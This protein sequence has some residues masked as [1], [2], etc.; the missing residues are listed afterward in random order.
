M[1]NLIIVVFSLFLLSA[2]STNDPINIF[3]MMSALEENDVPLKFKEKLE[4]SIGESYKYRIDG[5][6]SEIIIYVFDSEKE[7]MKAIDE[8]PWIYSNDSVSLGNIY[9]TYTPYG[10]V[11]KITL[12]EN[13]NRT[14]NELRTAD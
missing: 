1:K 3:E 12:S 6:K 13:L 11:E 5:E 4:L 8:I 2:C 7:R 9:I 10:E 14:I